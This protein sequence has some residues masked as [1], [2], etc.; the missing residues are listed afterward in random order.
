VGGNENDDSACGS[1][2][3]YV[4]RRTD[5]GWQQEAYLEASNTCAHAGSGTSAALSGRHTRGS[6]DRGE[7][8]AAPASTATRNSGTVYV[9]H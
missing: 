4:F 5:M 1:G 8:S 2:A 6:G 3:V 9:F 7:D